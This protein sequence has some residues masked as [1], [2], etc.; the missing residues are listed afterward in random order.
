MDLFKAT[1]QIMGMDRKVWARHAN[2][3]SG[4]S[5]LLSGPAVF[6]ALWSLW[7]I[8]WWAL[9]PISL[10]IIWIYINPRLFPP[11]THTQSWVTKGVLG[12]RVFI[13]RK[14]VPIPD[15]HVRMGWITSLISMVFVLIAA[16]GLLVQDFW[17]A[18][19]G[20]HASI[21]AKVWFLDRMVWLWEDMKEA[22]PQYQAWARAD[23]QAEDLDIE[24]EEI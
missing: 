18:F 2:P 24:T 14:G 3:L 13:N 6:F 12:E 20:W 5:R 11:P 4:Y 1:E 21:L 15:H 7:W 22:T 8:S 9:L 19:T 16:Y 23:W 17:A 10:I